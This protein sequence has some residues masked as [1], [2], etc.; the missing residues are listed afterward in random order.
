MHLYWI[1]SVVYINVLN[2]VMKNQAMFKLMDCQHRRSILWKGRHAL[3]FLR[4]W[5]ALMDRAKVLGSSLIK[6]WRAPVMDRMMKI[7]P[8][9][10]IAANA[11]LY[12]TLPVPSAVK[13]DLTAG[14]WNAR[15]SVKCL[16]VSRYCSDL[17][18][19]E[20]SS[21]WDATCC[22]LLKV[23]SGIHVSASQRHKQ[24]RQMSRPR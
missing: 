2:S 24:Q 15:H 21:I 13:H 20:S 3:G 10:K 22:W 19:I 23:G 12:L 6:Y 5:P 16:V 8:S 18:D 14:P 17:H 11:S 1:I 7:Q 4:A 9:I